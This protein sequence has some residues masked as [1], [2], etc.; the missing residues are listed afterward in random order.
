MVEMICC[1][2]PVHCGPVGPVHYVSPLKGL[3]TSFMLSS[4]WKFSVNFGKTK[5]RCF[6]ND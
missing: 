6:V 2:C 1:A 4:R 5:N 3:G